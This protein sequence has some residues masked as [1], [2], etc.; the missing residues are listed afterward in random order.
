MFGASVPVRH[1][2]TWHLLDREYKI[3][4]THTGIRININGK[5]LP[6]AMKKKPAS[7]HTSANRRDF[8]KKSALAF[9]AAAF[10]PSHAIFAKPELR[11]SK[12]EVVRRATVAP[13]DKVRLAACGVGNQAGGILNIFHNTGMA[14]VVAICDTDMGAPHT[15]GAMERYP[16][17]PRFHDFREMYDKVGHT[18]DAVSIGTPDFSHFPQTILAMSMGKHVFVEKPLGR[19]F[20]E[21]ELLIKAAKKYNVA[22]QM[23]NQG[24]CQ[25]NFYQF[26]TW[27]DQGIIEG[28][29]EITAHMNGRRR[30]H[31]WDT[32]MSRYPA[33]EPKPDTLDWDTWLMA[34]NHREYHRDLVNGQWRCWYDFGMGALGDWGAHIMDTFHRFLELGLPEEVDP[35]LIEGHNQLFFPQATTLAF[36]FPARGSM[37]PVTVTWY[38]GTENHPPIP[39]GYGGVEADPNIPPIE[40]RVVPAGQLP[41][42]KIIYGR[43]HIFKGGSHSSTLSLVP[44][45]KHEA[46]AS[47]LP[48]WHR[49][50]TNLYQ[51][52]LLACRGEQECYSKFEVSGVLS[53]VFCLGTIAQRLNARLHFDRQT[54]RFTDNE[55]ANLLLTGPPP[56]EGW[57]EFYQLA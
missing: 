22:T 49:S 10:V 24:H 57:E 32:T 39:E 33:A 8:L 56:R 11:N 45:S 27:V 2:K 12:G 25:D 1:Q 37:P 48:D 9:G 38:D 16:N 55:V 17:A 28:V 5:A 44:D 20:H 53:Q 43:D 47:E 31:G 13:S 19:T 51:N 40:G 14:E 3:H 7:T 30:W 26:K 23:G 34:A 4:D 35:L 50:E 29:T 52:F 18:F 15:T 42:G 36:R 6:K 41:A 46:M 54:K 21:N